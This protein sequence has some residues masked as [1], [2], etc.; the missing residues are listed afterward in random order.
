M[1]E[2][3]L[4]TG[5]ELFE[6]VVSIGSLISEEQL[7]SLRGGQVSDGLLSY[8][9]DIFD[10]CSPEE[11]NKLKSVIRENIKLVSGDEADLELADMVGAPWDC[12][13][14]E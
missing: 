5:E 12:F 6:Y 1:S 7:D 11:M 10:D 13:A 3:V 9:F 2:L 8:L 14:E 4:N